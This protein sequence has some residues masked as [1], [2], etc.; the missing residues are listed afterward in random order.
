[1]GVGVLSKVRKSAKIKEIKGCGTGFWF[2]QGFRG[3]C[4]G[5]VCLYHKTESGVCGSAG[6]LRWCVLKSLRLVDFKK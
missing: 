5:G 6:R 4:K 1:M 2:L 3:G